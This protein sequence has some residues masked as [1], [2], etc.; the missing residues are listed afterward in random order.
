VNTLEPTIRESLVLAHVPLLRHIAGRM[1][2]PPGVDR[3]DLL[4]WGMIGLL[5]AADTFDESRGLKF[6]TYAYPKIRGAILDALRRAD[7]LP[8]ERRE[9]LQE[10]QR[11]AAVLEQ[12]LGAPPTPEE[13]AERCELSA[14]DI[15]EALAMARVAVES[16][17]DEGWS[18]GSLGALLSDPRSE[19]PVGTAEWEEM[20]QLLAAS[21]QELPEPE[22][23]VILLYYGEEMLLRDIGEVLGVS[24]SRVSQIHSKA[25][26]RLNRKLVLTHGGDPR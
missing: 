21:I 7:A 12:E 15:D 24:E 25:V 8:R 10:I 2:L 9:Q 1:G 19:D 20:K 4:G 11:A 16:S 6:S 26:Y 23:T 22:R 3:G 18:V 5:A 14:D 13:I 17:L